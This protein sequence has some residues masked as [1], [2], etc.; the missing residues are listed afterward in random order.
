MNFSFSF[1]YYPGSLCIARAALTCQKSQST[2]NNSSI[3]FDGNNSNKLKPKVTN[4]LNIFTN[5]F[6]LLYAVFNTI[7]MC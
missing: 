7:C 1:N 2:I 5:G 3:T 4:A 6:N